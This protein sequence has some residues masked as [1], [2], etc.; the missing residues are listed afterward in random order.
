MVANLIT[1]LYSELCIILKDDKLAT[2]K[3]K[4]F[5]KTSSFSTDNLHNIKGFLKNFTKTLIKKNWINKSILEDDLLKR[6]LSTYKCS[7]WRNLACGYKDLLFPALTE[8]GKIQKDKISD[9]F[10]IFCGIQFIS[11]CKS[12]DVQKDPFWRTRLW[13]N[14]FLFSESLRNLFPNDTSLLTLYVHNLTF[15]FALSYEKA[16]LAWQSSERF[17]AAFNLLNQTTSN[18]IIKDI[19]KMDQSKMGKILNRICKFI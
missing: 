6:K 9:L 4:H 8:E 11:Y 14:F 12:S 16:P 17:E 15:H 3:F 19:S 1:S 7:D 5:L 13:V 2:E 10:D 18:N